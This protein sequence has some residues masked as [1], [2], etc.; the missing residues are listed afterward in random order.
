MF[1]TYVLHSDKFDRFY[2]GHTQNLESRLDEHNTGRTKSTKF[3]APWRLVY[4]EKF[5]TRD[6]AIER[7]KYFKTGSGRKY[8]KSKIMP[9]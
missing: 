6:E 7:E 8:Y 4:F 5:S 2:V 1:Y 9:T 3:Y